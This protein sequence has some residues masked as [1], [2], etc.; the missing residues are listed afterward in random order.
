M[1][2]TLA[3]DYRRRRIRIV[4]DLFGAVMSADLIIIGV[5][6]GRACF[7]SAAILVTCGAAIDVPLYE[8]NAS[9]CW[10]ET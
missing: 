3:E 4:D 8:L 1:T 10:P 5:Q 2:R 6:F 9:R 7:S